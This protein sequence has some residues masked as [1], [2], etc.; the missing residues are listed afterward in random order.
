MSVLPTNCRVITNCTS[1][2]LKQG[3]AVSLSAKDLKLSV[4]AAAS[5]WANKVLEAK[6]RVAAVDLYQGRSFSDAKAVTALLQGQLHVVSA[7]LGLV[8][9]NAQVPH[10]NL[11]I[12]NGTGSIRS[13]LTREGATPAIWWHTLTQ[14]LPQ[15]QSLHELISGDAATTTLLALP[16]TYLAMVADDLDQLSRQ[17]LAKV[18]I[19]TSSSSLSLLPAKLQEVCMPYDERLEGHTRYAGTRADFPQR[20]MRHFVQE[21]GAQAFSL[22]AANGAVNKALARLRKP[23]LPERTRCSDDE[24]IR[25]LKKNWSQHGGYQAPLLRFLRDDALVS[26]EQ[27]RFA[28]LWREAKAQIDPS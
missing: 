7:G 27:S 17:Q 22:E 1:R 11:T 26:C 6:H 28:S 25:L 16:S 5:K 21:L 12:S 2:K 10:Y 18:R 20:A 3:L 14:R 8:H 24:I 19:F 23:A 9:G 13:L 15:S 4:D